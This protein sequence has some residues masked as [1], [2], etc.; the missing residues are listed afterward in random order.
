[1]VRWWWFGPAV[2]KK[3]IERELKAMK[4]GGIGG[5]EVQCTY[6]LAVDGGVGDGP[7]KNF[8]FLSP[9]HLE[10]LGFAA[11][12]CK[13][14][15]LR[16]DLT[17]GSGW[18]YGGPMF[19]AAEGAGKLETAVV[20]VRAGA[21]NVAVPAQRAG[22]TVIAAFAG[23][24]GTVPT[25]RGAADGGDDGTEGDCD[26][27]WRGDAAGGVCRRGG[28]VFHLWQ[29]GDAGEAGGQRARGM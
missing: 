4:A 24:A 2:T 29:D 17:L 1:M 21:V 23:P 16:M 25:G 19:S 18:P 10:M 9:E 6:P 13:E 3:G 22:R 20:Q 11:A 8:K 28:A 5:V 14:L 27:Q 15:G 26:C 12:K 7:V